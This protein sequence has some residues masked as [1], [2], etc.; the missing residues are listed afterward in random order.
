MVKAEMVK[1]EVA[2]LQLLVFPISAFYFQLF[3][4]RSSL[5]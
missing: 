5:D 4:R 3:P 2:R 1:A